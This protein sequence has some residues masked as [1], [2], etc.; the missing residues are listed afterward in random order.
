MA[1]NELSALL[2]RERELLGLLT[3]KLEEEQLL[4]TTGNTRWL[5]HATRE[6]EQVVDHLRSE[7]LLRE[8]AVAALAAEWDL[9]NN[10]SLRD[11]AANA[12]DGP[13]GEIFAAHLTALVALTGRIEEL[14]DA[15]DVFLRAAVKST[16]E[17][18]ANLRAD[19][20]TYDSLGLASPTPGTSVLDRQL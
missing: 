14:R 11:I 6:V 2:W 9:G 10:P 20:G 15:N 1:A 7:A 19:A 4:L 5:H 16:Q 12:P 17:T 18:L 3:F 8:V 13:W